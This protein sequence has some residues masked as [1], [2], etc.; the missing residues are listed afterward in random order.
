MWAYAGQTL[1]QRGELKNAIEYFSAI[2]RMDSGRQEAIVDEANALMMLGQVS[3]AT[4]LQK[5]RWLRPLMIYGAA[6][7]YSV[8]KRLNDDNRFA[9]AKEYIEPAFLLFGCDDLESNAMQQPIFAVITSEYIGTADDLE[10]VELSANLNRALLTSLISTRRSRGYPAATYASLASKERTQ[11]AVLAARR[12]DL[13]AFERHA[14]VAESALPLGITLVEDSYH[15]LVATGNQATA[16]KW[17]KRYEQRLLEHLA[18]WPKDASSHNN[19]AWMYARCNLKLEE[20]LE[21]SQTAVELSP[22]SAVLLDTLA[23]VQFRLN[24]YSAA[25]NSMQRCIQLDPRDPHLRKQLERFLKAE[26]EH[27]K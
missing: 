26:L 10:D 16:E 3:E 27:R 23:E 1:Q 4:E 25:V 14:A 19:L 9:L 6:S 2:R 12:G 17:F 21:H 13:A 22:H 20:A 8:A 24:Q 7:W 11:W 18:R 15:E 5:S